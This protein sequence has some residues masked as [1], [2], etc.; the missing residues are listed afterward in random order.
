MTEEN[1]N[2][3]SVKDYLDNVFSDQGIKSDITINITDKS[4]QKT[5]AYLVGTALVITLMVF[6]IKGILKN[7]EKINPVKKV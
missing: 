7:M 2:K 6:G 4:L 3:R 1:Q 5:S